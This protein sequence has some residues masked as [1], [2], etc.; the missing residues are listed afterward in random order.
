MKKFKCV[1]MLLAAIMLFSICTPFTAVAQDNMLFADPANEA[2][3]E[4]LDKLGIYSFY[5]DSGLF[6]EDNNA[7]KRIDAAKSLVSLLG[8]DINSVSGTVSDLFIDVPDYYEYAGVVSTAVDLGLMRGTA[9]GV[10]APEEKILLEHFIKSVVVAL[11]YDFKAQAR[12]GYP[13]GYIYVANELGLLEGISAKYSEDLTRQMLIRILYNAL[14]VDICLPTAVAGGYVEYKLAEDVT[15]LTEYHDI[16][17]ETDI[18]NSNNILSLK[19]YFKPSDERILIGEDVIY[20][21]NSDIFAYAGYEVEYYYE[22]VGEEKSL[23]YFTLSKDNEVY[24]FAKHQI[25]EINKNEVIGTDANGD[26]ES[27]DISTNADIF[28]NG[29]LLSADVNEKLKSFTDNVVLIDNNDDGEADVVFIEDYTYEQVDFVDTTRQILYLKDGSV[30]YGDK[31]LMSVS[32]LN[33]S[34]I[35]IE[36]L[37]Q[38]TI[39]GVGTTD[40]S[41]VLVMKV[42]GLPMGIKV[43]SVSANEATDAEGKVYYL[44][45][46]MTEKMKKN[47]KGGQD[48]AVGINNDVI[49]WADKGSE[50]VKLGFLIKAASETRGLTTTSM[51][52]IL[53]TDSVVSEYYLEDKIRIND[54][55]VEVKDVAEYLKK[56]KANLNTGADSDTA[57]VVYYMTDDEG[58]LKRLYTAGKDSSSKLVMKYNYHEMGDAFLRDHGYGSAVYASGYALSDSV[59]IFQV[60]LED[61][62]K[63]DNKYFTVAKYDT[64]LFKDGSSCKFESYVADANDI[65][66]AVMVYYKTATAELSKSNYFFLVEKISTV[67]DEDGDAKVKLSGYYYNSKVDYFVND[68]VKL[69]ELSPGDIGIF[70]LDTIDN[71]I[72]FEKIYD[73]ETDTVNPEYVGSSRADTVAVRVLHVY[74]APAG[75]D[76]IET[77]EGGFENGIPG[78]ENK[79]LFNFIPYN[80]RNNRLLSFDINKK[81]GKVKG[82]AKIMDYLHDNQNYARIVIRFGNNYQG[83]AVI[84]Q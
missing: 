37:S 83:D 59:P 66:P 44:H 18:V 32:D 2:Y 35:D 71:I 48:A 19:S 22:L 50:A 55:P 10:F 4:F 23:V 68:D 16:Y 76:F 64:T 78:E 39:V 38:G 15:V 63:Y 72:A 73:F 79:V 24:K 33:G 54:E 7:V 14:D 34:Q 36:T 45:G 43:A 29:S 67:A 12:G 81:E 40:K 75:S 74:N 31:K 57:Q 84:Y 6:F 56:T 60:P 77:Y 46:N 58:N 3:A 53:S 28:M 27:V 61:M 20:T 49:V 13:S 1:R 65:L 26:E 70:S 11:G 80:R 62:D 69:P 8:H 52:K 30:N 5:S 41:D 17:K 82:P 21:E 42:I 25:V 51:V 9:N 47:I